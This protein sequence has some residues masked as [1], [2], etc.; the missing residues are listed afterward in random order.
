MIT[1]KPIIHL[2]ELMSLVNSLE[3]KVGFLKNLPR[4]GGIRLQLHSGI[5]YNDDVMSEEFNCWQWK[6]KGYSSTH[7]YIPIHAMKKHYDW[8]INSYIYRY[9]KFRYP[10]GWTGWFKQS[11]KSKR[12][13][14]WKEAY[15][16]ERKQW[17]QLKLGA[18]VEP[19]PQSVRLRGQSHPEI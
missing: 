1:G 16:L 4:C 12:T 18:R 19:W 13:P 6:V 7:N 2:D 11:L 3:I 5:D 10:H 14:C 15:K 9:M 8:F 17:L